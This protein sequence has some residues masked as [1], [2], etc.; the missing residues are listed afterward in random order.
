M[1]DEYWL[2][3]ILNRNG[4]IYTKDKLD[5]VTTNIIVP[6]IR[7]QPYLF[8]CVDNDVVYLEKPDGKKIIPSDDYIEIKN[9]ILFIHGDWEYGIHD[10]GIVYH[11]K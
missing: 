8:H 10:F 4:I 3:E 7:K 1:I 9:G 2:C 11:D 5:K 6:N